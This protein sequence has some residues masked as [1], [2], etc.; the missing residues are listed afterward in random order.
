MFDLHAHAGMGPQAI[1]AYLTKMG[2]R[3]RSGEFFVAPSIRNIL[4]NP[5][6]RG[7]LR[8]GDSFSEPFEDLRIIEDV[9]FNRSQELIEQQANTCKEKRRAPKKSSE[10]CLLTS[11]VFA[12]PVERG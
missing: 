4:R 11:R 7:V 1:S 8:S 12:V 5:M 6:Y 2:I 3:N 10:N 9:V